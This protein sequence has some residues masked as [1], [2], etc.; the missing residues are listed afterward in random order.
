MF[1]GTTKMMAGDY[2]GARGDLQRAVKM[3]PKLPD[4]Y[5]YYGLALS[6]GGETAGAGDAFRKELIA[7]PN[8]F[9]SNLRLGAPARQGPKREKAPLNPERALCAASG[10]PS[11]QE[12]VP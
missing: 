9:T 12:F 10:R 2:A 6:H 5:C 3:N 7:N 1:L 4:V 11:R 8:D